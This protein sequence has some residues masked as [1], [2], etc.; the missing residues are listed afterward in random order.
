MV[1]LLALDNGVKSRFAT[2]DEADKEDTEKKWNWLVSE[3]IQL[4]PGFEGDH[5]IIDSPIA[6][7]ELIGLGSFIKNLS[8]Q[9]KDRIQGYFPNPEAFL[10]MMRGFR[11]MPID[12]VKENKCIEFL[13][14]EISVVADA[15]KYLMYHSLDR[16]ELIEKSTAWQKKYS[17]HRHASIISRELEAWERA[18]EEGDKGLAF[19]ILVRNLAWNILMRHEWVMDASKGSDDFK[20]VCQYEKDI[21]LRLIYFYLMQMEDGANL[22]GAYLFSRLERLGGMSG[23]S[24]ESK[25]EWDYRPSLFKKD[26]ELLDSDLSEFL[27]TGYVQ[28]KQRHPLVVITCDRKKQKE[29]LQAIIRGVKFVN[30]TLGDLDSR[31]G[32]DYKIP[33]LISIN[34]GILI[35]VDQDCQKLGEKIDVRQLIIDAGIADG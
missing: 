6:N 10:Y 12:P 28:D 19:E 17:C 7:L 8:Q 1:V 25:K 22:S 24:C 32:F 20:E 27:V 14:R 15:L 3:V 11:G 9:E 34:P 33:D 21:V 26:K 30:K 31:G 5:K 23:K 2:I 35:V 18:L 4:I 29:R 13:S 16:K